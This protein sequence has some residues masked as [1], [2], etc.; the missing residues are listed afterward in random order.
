MITLL[1]LGRSLLEK[2]ILILIHLYLN[3]A[4][5]RYLLVDK[6]RRGIKTINKV[7]KVI[8]LEEALVTPYLAK[9]ALTERL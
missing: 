9:A 7:L 8:E 6:D 5:Q 1:A 3:K 4:L 2:L